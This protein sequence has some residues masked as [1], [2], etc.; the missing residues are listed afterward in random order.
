MEKRDGQT[1]GDLTC[2][3]LRAL[4][5]R[6]MIQESHLPQKSPVTAVSNCRINL[7]VWQKNE[8]ARAGLLLSFIRNTSLGTPAKLLLMFN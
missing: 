2:G 7:A 3:P 1:L 6:L 8:L 4:I 5:S